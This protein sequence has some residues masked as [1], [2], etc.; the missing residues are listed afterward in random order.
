MLR[1]LFAIT[2]NPLS[3]V[4]TALT[5][6]SAALFVTL[7]VI[8]L[9]GFQGGPY[10]GIITFIA[11]PS[12]FVLGLLLIPV[13][14]WV[15]RRRLARADGRAKVD[16]PVIDLNRG[17][18]RRN[19]VIFGAATLVNF[20]ILAVATYKGVEFSD[21][22]A[23]CGQTCHS[24]MAPEYTAYQRSPHSRVHCVDCHIGPGA[25]WFVKSKMSGA[26]QVVSTALDLYPRPIP[27][28]VHNLRPARDTCE[29][30]HWPTKFHGDR[31]EVVTRYS[32]DEANTPL[33]TVMLLKVGGIQ[34]REAKGIHWHVDPELQIRYKSDES[35]E[36]IT[37][38]EMSRNG[39]EP[40][41]YYPGGEEP[42]G[43]AEGFEGEWRVMDCVDCHNRP[44]HIYGLPNT[45][46]DDALVNGRVDPTLPFFKREGMKL[47]QQEWA[48]H[49]EARE[50]IPTAL[51]RFYEKEFPEVAS[52][53]ASTVT[54]A[55]TELARIWTT[56]VHPDMNIDWGT[57]PDHIGHESYPGCFRCH[58]GD[59]ATADGEYIS[60]DCETCHSLLA[61]EEED[62]EILAELQP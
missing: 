23:F 25:D 36:T 34:G 41:V 26:W 50:A 10:L 52:T 51:Q 27:T 55:G 18:A 40:T 15:R 62:P 20:A 5:T 7:Y 31:L 33:T 11:L 57:Y 48:S 49:E 58:D 44:T 21:S 6:A 22:N 1:F 39:E 9:I 19:V 59:H 30:C 29:Q 56:N 60:G 46:L 16:F 54:A 45:E 37:V 38:V 3:L 24:V 14:M 4:G 43:G 32:E 53:R 17:T 13:G 47:L 8:E 61:W 28:P 35:R 42:E 12:M 2:R